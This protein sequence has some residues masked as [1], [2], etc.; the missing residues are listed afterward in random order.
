MTVRAAASDTALPLRSAWEGY[1]EGAGFF[2]VAASWAAWVEV[3]R[4]KETED[5][6]VLLLGLVVVVLVAVGAEPEEK[7]DL[8][9]EEAEEV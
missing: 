5:L 7:V 4:V 8:R 2:Q 1:G 6:R 9:E 3:S